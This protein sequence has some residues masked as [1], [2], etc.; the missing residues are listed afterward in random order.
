[1]KKWLMSVILITFSI[2]SFSGLAFADENVETWVDRL[3]VSPDKEWNITFNTSITEETVNDESVFVKNTET[4][5]KIDVSLN[6]INDGENLVIEPAQP[7]TVDQAYELH[8]KNGLTSVQG[9]ET[10]KKAIILP[11][12]VSKAYQIV[13]L[14]SGPKDWEL[15]SS[16]DTLD[17]AVAEAK[18]EDGKEGVIHEGQLMWAPKGSQ[19]FSKGFTYLYSDEQLKDAYS[20]VSGSNEMEYVR[21]TENSIEVVLAG[22]T[23]FIDH[24][25]AALVPEPFKEGG[26]YYENVGGDLYHRL[27]LNGYS[28]SYNYGQAPAD[29]EEGEKVYSPDGS[30]NWEDAKFFNDLLLTKQSHYNE[31]QLDQFLEEQYPY[32]NENR[33]AGLGEAFI[34]AEEKYDVNALYLM[35]H[36]IHESAWGTS[37]IARDKNNL[38]GYKAYDGSAYDSAETFESLE[39]GI[40]FIAKKVLD[41]EYLNPVNW[42]YYGAYLGDKSGGMNIKYASD[43]FWGQK[44]AGYMYRADKFLGGHDR[45]L[46]EDGY[47]VEEKFLTEEEKKEQEEEEN[48]DEDNTDDEGT[49]PEPD[50]PEDPVDEETTP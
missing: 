26:S 38:Y 4:G 47:V 12:N 42:K 28:P 30:F 48:D 50:N 33:L 9:E 20:Y 25:S 46:L 24:D 43:P 8:I 5:E 13:K 17:E 3:N 31:E 40:D 10:L 49:D 37:D 45:K 2:C 21:S 41:E 7:Y 6:L 14:Q 44:I 35:A 15:A 23:Y 22:E 29:L 18:Q 39:S 19:L 34:A 27:Y 1:M 11:F 16:Y 36:A 32:D